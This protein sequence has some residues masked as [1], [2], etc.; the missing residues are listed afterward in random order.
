MKN[1]FLLGYLTQM[2][3]TLQHWAEEE[4]LGGIIR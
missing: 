2:P 1:H 4:A 3:D